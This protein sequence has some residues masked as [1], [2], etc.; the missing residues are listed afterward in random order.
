MLLES[1]L[2]RTPPFAAAT[3]DAHHVAFVVIK[4]GVH[5]LGNDVGV[6]KLTITVAKT[7]LRHLVAN[8]R[9]QRRA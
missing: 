1:A 5:K 7:A 4:R 6:P 9:N 3:V 2:Q 8:A